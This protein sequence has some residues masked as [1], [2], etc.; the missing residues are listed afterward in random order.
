M[1]C[2]VHHDKV[3]TSTVRVAHSSLQVARIAAENAVRV[4]EGASPV[5][6]TRPAVAAAKQR[7]PTQGQQGDR[8]S[9]PPSP[10]RSE[11]SV[12]EGV[13]RGGFPNAPSKSRFFAEQ[14]KPPAQSAH[15]F[16]PQAMAQ[17]VAGRM[18]LAAVQAPGFR[19]AEQRELQTT[20][21]GGALGDG[22]ASPWEAAAAEGLW[23]RCEDGTEAPPA[24]MVDAAGIARFE[25]EGAGA[26]RGG[27]GN[28]QGLGSSREYPPP[29]VID[30]AGI[31]RFG[32]GAGPAGDTE[33]TAKR[34]RIGQGG[35]R[36][37]R[38]APGTA[39]EGLGV[40]QADSE[41]D[42]NVGVSTCPTGL[43][44]HGVADCI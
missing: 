16:G 36:V 28:A 6:P 22:G 38:G 32:R 44:R 10:S 42:H 30:G 9:P 27:K 18:I 26:G 13:A 29:I 24:I 35:G 17:G 25:R 11:S 39:L 4:A 19:R 15:P 20:R 31:A 5:L 33:G 37:G 14:L 8:A 23:G 21:G 40:R 2:L 7:W 41:V 12:A 34:P 3:Q 43:W 1:N